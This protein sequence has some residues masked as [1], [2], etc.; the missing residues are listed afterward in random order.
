MHNRRA[1]IGKTSMPR[2][3]DPTPGRTMDPGKNAA[4]A[5]WGR[6]LS[7]LIGI[8][9]ACAVA[10]PAILFGRDD[11]P[12]STY[13]MF[14][15]RRSTIFE[16]P[17]ALGVRKDGTRVYISP[18]AVANDE[19]LQAASAIKRAIRRGPS[20]ALAL[21][22]RIIGRLRSRSELI[23][24]EL[25]TARFDAVR[26]FGGDQQPLATRVHARCWPQK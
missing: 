2:R 23:A 14:S 26:Y 25:A 6:L 4:T 18:E 1:S 7:Y 10:A 8:T 17:R 22:Q 24:V 16:I 11:F 15:Y 3:A 5:R 13:P 21:C 19:V 20:A 9:T 12:L